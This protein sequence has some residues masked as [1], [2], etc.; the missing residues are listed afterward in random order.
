MA[1]VNYL[2]KIKNSNHISQQKKGMEDI[3]NFFQQVESSL[4]QDPFQND[5]DDFLSGE[6]KQRNWMN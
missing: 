1:A 3:Q 5:I 6:V 4:Y 2:K